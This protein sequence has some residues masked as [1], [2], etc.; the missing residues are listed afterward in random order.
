ML[1]LLVLIFRLLCQNGYIGGDVPTLD[2]EITAA[3]D[4]HIVLAVVDIDHIQHH[5]LV[6]GNYQILFNYLLTA[7]L[8]TLED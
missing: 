2:H 4:Q 5:V 1:H 7:L 8:P 3:R 6:F